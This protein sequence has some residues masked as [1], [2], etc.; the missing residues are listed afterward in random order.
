MKDT[1][2]SRTTDQRYYGVLEGIV[3]DN[4]DPEKLGRVKVRFP[5]FDDQTVTDWCRLAHLY[6]GPGY[7]SFYIPEI[8][9]EVVVS[10]IH[11]DMRF[12]IVMG[13]LYNGKDKPATHRAEDKDEKLIRTKAG[14]QLLFSDTEDDRFTEI[15]TTGGHLLT[16]H[17][18]EEKVALTTSG[19]HE[20]LLDDGGGKITVKTSGGQTVELDA[21]SDK[22][23]VKAATVTLDATNVKLGGDGAVEPLVLG[24]L[25]M[26]LFNAHVH[27]S[28]LPG[29]PT[30]PPVTPMTPAQLSTISK[31]S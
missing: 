6:A 9:D 28:T 21:N 13:G 31:T 8:D 30:S 22:I 23:T 20:A 17:D 24:N 4:V 5:W 1:P 16:L 26:I 18:E 3:V 27:T 19:G 15:R 7:G 14:H 12:P 25:F 10:F 29:T 11:G 2:R